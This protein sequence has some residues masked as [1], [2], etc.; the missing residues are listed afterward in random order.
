MYSTIKEI[1]VEIEQKINQI[2]GN[3]NKSIAP[4]FIDMMLN[5]TALKYIDTI[6][7]DKL[8]P[9]RE[10]F[11]ETTKRYDEIS[12]LISRLDLTTYVSDLIDGNRVI[13]YSYAYIPKNYYRYISSTSDLYYHRQIK[14]DRL[15]TKSYKSIIRFINYTIENGYEISINNIPIGLSSILSNYGI[16]NN[17]SENFEFLNAIVDKINRIG[18]RASL[19][20]YNTDRDYF[21]LVIYLDTNSDNI[22]INNTSIIKDDLLENGF[23]IKA[24]PSMSN[25]GIANDLLPVDEIGNILSS[26]YG[27]KNRQVNPFC[28]LIKQREIYNSFTINGNQNRINVYNGKDFE[29]FN[30]NLTYIRKP[31]LFSFP[32]NLVSDLKCTNRFIDTVVSDILLQLKD[33]SFNI[34]KQNTN[35]E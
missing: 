10:G 6:C 1:H 34:V 3:L 16:S 29:V 18:I 25:K 33:N 28:E 12:N 26:Y 35:L 13:K 8:S 22:N 27:I 23:I 20:E 21:P 14:F 24:Y 9:T 2:T 19:G 15:Y 32:L 30:I 5:R 31:L 17:Q 4:E 7:S 11:E